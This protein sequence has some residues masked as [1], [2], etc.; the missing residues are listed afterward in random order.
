MEKRRGKRER[1]VF[2]GK[3]KNRDE[4]RATNQRE[5]M[6][7]KEERRKKKRSRG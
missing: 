2:K 1:N 4:M 6:T 7:G 5:G 3:N